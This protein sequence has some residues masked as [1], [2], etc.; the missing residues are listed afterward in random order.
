MHVFLSTVKATAYLFL[1]VEYYVVCNAGVLAN[2]SLL[3]I[4]ESLGGL[5]LNGNHLGGSMND[6]PMLGAVNGDSLGRGALTSIGEIERRNP[7]HASLHYFKN[8]QQPNGLRFGWMTLADP[9]GRMF[10][11]NNLTGAAQWNPPMST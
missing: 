2:G 6:K 10:Y 4:N 7:M 8:M 1:C 3:G 11:F 9:E 5:S